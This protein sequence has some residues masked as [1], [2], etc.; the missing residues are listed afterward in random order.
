MG[1]VSD[2]L[3]RQHL[4]MD[5]CVIELFSHLPQLPHGVMQV[6]LTFAPVRHKE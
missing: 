4:H 1:V 5:I 6:P 2:H 3:L